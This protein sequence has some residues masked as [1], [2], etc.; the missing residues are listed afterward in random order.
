M[1]SKMHYEANRQFAQTLLVSQFRWYHLCASPAFFR[2]SNSN[3]P[4]YHGWSPKWHLIASARS[5]V[6]M[7]PSA[8]NP[9]CKPLFS[10]P[11][12]CIPKIEI[13]M[14]FSE[15]YSP[16]TDCSLRM[17]ATVRQPCSGVS[18]RHSS[19]TA[20]VCGQISPTC[21]AWNDASLLQLAENVWNLRTRQLM[22]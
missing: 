6:S 12:V 20:C 5:Q 15:C 13:A 2:Q 16:F 21:R 17:Q 3:K 10:H 19:C 4:S 14:E 18:A 9:P 11:T 22:G 8:Q 1:L 7:Q